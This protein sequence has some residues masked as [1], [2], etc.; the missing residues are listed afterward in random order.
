VLSLLLA[1][2][3]ELSLS[4]LS[5][6][7]ARCSL[8]ALLLAFSCSLSSSFSLL[9]SRFSLLL[10]LRSAARVFLFIVVEL[11]AFSRFDLS[12]SARPGGR[13]RCPG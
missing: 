1:L 10:G 8:L 2:T 11:S 9:A 7:A 4:L 13:S 5:L 12:P 6:L 3:A